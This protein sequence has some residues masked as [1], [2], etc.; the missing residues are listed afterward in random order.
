MAL[1]RRVF[2]HPRSLARLNA[3]THPAVFRELR[4]QRTAARRAGRPF[5]A[6]IP[7]LYETGTEADWDA[8]LCVAAPAAVARRRLR[9]RGWAPEQIAARRAAQWPVREKCRRADAVVRNGGTRR[10]LRRAVEGAWK[11]LTEEE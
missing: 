5:A 9:R 1:A 11:R 6:V 4:R 3:L 10:A 7:L 2:G 8:V